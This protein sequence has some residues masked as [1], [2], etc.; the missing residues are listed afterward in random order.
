MKLLK[1]TKLLK[2][3]FDAYDEEFVPAGEEQIHEFTEKCTLRSV[4]VSVQEQLVEFYRI[5]NGVPCLN[6]FEFHKIDDETIFEWW[7][8]NKELWLGTKDDDVL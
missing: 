7:D 1:Y 4:P 6:G 8:D 3:L 5:T 2:P